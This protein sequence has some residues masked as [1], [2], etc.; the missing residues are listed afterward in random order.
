MALQEASAVLTATSALM[1]LP[2]RS[3]DIW[4]QH[5]YLQARENAQAIEYRRMSQAREANQAAR[6]AALVGS[7]AAQT[8]QE[9]NFS[10]LRPWEGWEP[11]RIVKG[12]PA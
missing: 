6:E 5:D 3:V 4:A 8:R 11:E 12:E 9:A 1:A 7:A 10:P 2:T